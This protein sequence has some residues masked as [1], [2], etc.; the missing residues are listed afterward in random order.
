MDTFARGNFS[1]DYEARID[2]DRL[3]RG[4]VE[5]TRDHMRERGLDA[6]L[7]WQDENVR[8][9]TSQRAIM[10]QYRSV[11]HYGVLLTQEAGPVLLTSGGEVAR[12]RETMPWLAHAEAIPHMTEP[13]LVEHV[14]RDVILPYLKKFG[15]EKGTIGIDAATFTMRRV[16][17]EEIPGARWADGESFMHAARVQKLP[18]EIQVLQEATAIADAVTQTAI[19]CVRAGVRECEVAG[20]AMRTLFRLGGEF[21]H[22]ASPFVASGERMSPPTRFATDKIIRHGDVVFIDIGAMWGGYFGDVGRTVICGRPS[23][24]QR[25]IYTAVHQCLRAGVAQMRPGNTN[26]QAARAFVEKAAEHGLEKNFIHLYIGHGC[27]VS[28]NEPP[29]IGE[30]A[31]GAAEVELKP[32]MVFAVEPLIWVPGVRGGGGV[33]IEDMIWVREDGPEVMSRAPYCEDLLLS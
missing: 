26:V 2:W 20:E 21:A 18:E 23:R 6:L 15:V 4:R 10:L 30:A 11:T 32:G 33:R 13:G 24:R 29:Y 7:L 14:A 25:E 19:D 27:G 12:V 17:E 16:F 28:P 5:K 3:R 1:V 31:K 9:L 22:L 8:Y